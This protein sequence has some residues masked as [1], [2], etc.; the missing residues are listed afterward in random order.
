MKDLKKIGDVSYKAA[1]KAIY[2]GFI[3]L[4]LILGL[5][6]VDFG[7]F[8]NQQPMWDDSSI[9]FDLFLNILWSFFIFRLLL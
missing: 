4:V 1:K 8:M 5:K 7:N 9:Y 3:P 2:F 6:T